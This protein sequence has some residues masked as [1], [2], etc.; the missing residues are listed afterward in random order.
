MT[1]S[2]TDGGVSRVGEPNP[3]AP[4]QVIPGP[5]VQVV[6]TVMYRGGLA[7]VGK[8]SG[9]G[10]GPNGAN[11]RRLARKRQPESEIDVKIRSVQPTLAHAAAWNR[12]W[13]RLLVER[14]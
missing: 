3:F 12:L 9:E 8:T 13:N 5:F 11:A 7:P 14:Q 1:K 2:T 10:A 6:S 4:Q